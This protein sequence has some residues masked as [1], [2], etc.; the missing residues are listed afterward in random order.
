MEMKLNNGDKGVYIARELWDELE[1]TQQGGID[2]K[3]GIDAYLNSESV[4]IKY[5]GTIANTNNIYHEIY[6]I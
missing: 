2:D 5:D 6:E 4:Q 1:L 3:N